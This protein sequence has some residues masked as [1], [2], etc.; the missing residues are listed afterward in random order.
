MYK[1]EMTEIFQDWRN[2]LKDS[3]AVRAIRARLD[4]ITLGHLGDTKPVGGGVFELR[5]HLSPG[6]RLYFVNKTGRIILLLCGG[7][8]S[9]QSKD[10]ARAQKLAREI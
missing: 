10:I 2:S 9:S 6:Y 1:V 4:H 7:N 5:M 8:K 3:K